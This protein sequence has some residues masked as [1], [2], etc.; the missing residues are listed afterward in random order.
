MKIL[1]ATRLQAFL[2]YDPKEAYAFLKHLGC[3]IEPRPIMHQKYYYN[4]AILEGTDLEVMSK[5]ITSS[6]Y[7]STEEVPKFTKSVFRKVTQTSL[8][9]PLGQEVFL[10]LIG[11][12]IGLTNERHYLQLI[13]RSSEHPIDIKKLMNVFK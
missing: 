13:D 4:F 10:S 11:L 12:N 6:V 1:A 9:W 5:R 3:Q 7:R 8:T 2:D